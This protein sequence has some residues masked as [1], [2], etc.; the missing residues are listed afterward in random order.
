[1]TGCRS[2]PLSDEKRKRRAQTRTGTKQLSS[3]R[4]LPLVTFRC[5]SAGD[6]QSGV[7]SFGFIDERHGRWPT[8]PRSTLGAGR[9]NWRVG[10]PE[11]LLRACSSVLVID[12]PSDDVPETLAR[13]GRSVHV[14]GGPGPADYSIRELADGS[15]TAR[16]TGRPPDHVDLVYVHRPIDELPQI[17]A[18]ARELGARALW[19]QSGLTSE[20]A[21]DPRGCW[22][23]AAESQRARAL[24]EAAG[25]LYVDDRYIADAAHEDDD[26]DALAE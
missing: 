20:G 9:D 14:K 5:E 7:H 22:L 25:L 17:V 18:T 16:K 24:A 1:M 15:V 19:Y 11:D 3:P 6:S 26:I 2:R 8:V 23:P 21:K 4:T 10:A 13:G 12:W